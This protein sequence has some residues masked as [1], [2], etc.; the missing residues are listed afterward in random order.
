MAAVK[1]PMNRKEN[2][3]VETK[4]LSP[5]LLQNIDAYWRAANYPSAGQ[6]HLYDNPLLKR[7]W[8]LADVKHIERGGAIGRAAP[9]HEKPIAAVKQVEL[10]KAAQSPELPYIDRRISDANP[11]PSPPRRRHQRGER[12][13]QSPSSRSQGEGGAHRAATGG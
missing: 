11:S 8:A 2:R 6:I 3:S 12:A 9:T 1:M 4:T 5:E 10:G 7:L 13:R